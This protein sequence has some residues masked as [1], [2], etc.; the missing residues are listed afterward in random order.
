MDLFCKNYTIDFEI[1]SKMKKAGCYKIMYGVENFNQE[2]LNVYLRIKLEDIRKV[3]K[4]TRK[5]GVCRSQLWLGIFMILGKL[6]KTIL[7]N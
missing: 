5:L 6:T 1:L 7:E 2:I 4:L 3:I